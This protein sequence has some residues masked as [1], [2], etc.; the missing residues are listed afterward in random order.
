MTHETLRQHAR[1][2][3]DAG[4][5]AVDPIRAIHR[6]VRR[7]GQM[8]YVGTT[9]YDL[10]AYQHVYVVGGGKAG[11][12]MSTAIEAILGDRITQ[13]WVNVKYA[14]VLP[15]QH[16]TLHEAG[17]PVPDEAG[18]QGTRRIL[19]LLEAAT[20]QDLVL[21]VISGG[22]S[23]LL[24]AP[25]NGITLAEKQ[26]LTK[27]LLQCG[28]TINEI[29]AIRKHISAIKGGHLARLAAPATIITLLLSD[30]IGDP[31]D[32][33]ASGPTAPDPNTFQDCLAILQKYDLLEDIPSAVATTIRQ[34]M[35]GEIP[36]TPKPGDPVFAHTQNFI[37][38][39]NGIAAR[40]AAERALELG[41]HP[42]IVSTFVEGE[43]REVAKMHAA[44]V[45]EI[46]HSG[47]PVPAPACII[48]GGETTVT[49]QGQ[50]LG[51][52]NQEFVLAAAIEISGL[53][54]VV[55]LSAGTDGTDGPT[56]AAGAVADGMTLRR[57]Q[58]GGLDP[59]TALRNNDAYHF[60]EALHDLIKTGPTHTNVMD[61]R[62]M[63]VGV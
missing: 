43:T 32:I 49:I 27:R 29:N 8:L 15:T 54:R 41:Y 61:L 62:I 22:G 36:E 42:L 12:S 60:F 55:V 52:R 28:A 4:V 5:Q 16:I 11:A 58:Q 56:D 47:Q 25:V 3:F 35:A 33:I 63:L 17:H 21:C 53:E 24:P 50:G 34:G 48:T 59:L 45:K 10:N 6:H 39:S 18:V 13:G 23:A 44:I 31:L 51:G 38:A 7:D 14:H 57:T 2:I 19:D 30:V 1:A 20:E 46:Q 26:A 9:A 40:A 37:V